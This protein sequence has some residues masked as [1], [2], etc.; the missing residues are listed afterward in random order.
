MEILIGSACGLVMGTLFTSAW[1]IMLS[2]SSRGPFKSLAF[3]SRPSRPTN[4]TMLLPLIGFAGWGIVG[5]MLGVLFFAAEELFPSDGL[6][7]PNLAFTI[8]V[9]LLTL[10]ALVLALLW[11]RRRDWW[12]AYGLGVAFIGLFGWLMPW[13]AE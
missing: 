5:G 3:L 2:T 8:F 7:S 12:E 4:L 1:G 10:N 6:G 11:E 13:L 9:L